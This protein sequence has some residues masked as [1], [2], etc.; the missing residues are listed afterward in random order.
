MVKPD[1]VLITNLTDIDEYSDK[2]ILDNYNSRWVIE[3]FFKFLKT[4]FKFQHMDEKYEIQNKKMYI[5]E[6]ILRYIVKSIDRYY[7]SN[8][9][10]KIK[11]LKKMGV[12]WNVSKNKYKKSCKRSL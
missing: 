12:I 10:P 2:Q 7:W 11:K 9:M 4:N 6:L 3:V 1:C 8:K 5:C